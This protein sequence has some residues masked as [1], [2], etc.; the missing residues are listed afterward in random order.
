M[1]VPT[2]PKIMTVVAWVMLVS[3][4]QIESLFINTRERGECDRC[5]WV[6]YGFFVID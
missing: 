2:A 3:D 1:R 6:D 4:S 5:S